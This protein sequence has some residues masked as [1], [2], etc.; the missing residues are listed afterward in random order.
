MVLT[1]EMEKDFKF[2]A[3]YSFVERYKKLPFGNRIF[4][5]NKMP[6]DNR[7]F[8]NNKIM[9]ATNGNVFLW[10]ETTEENPDGFSVWEVQGKN[11]VEL[12]DKDKEELRNLKLEDRVFSKY[13]NF[14][15]EFEFNWDK[16]IPLPIKLCSK[17]QQ[18]DNDKCFFDFAHND[19]I[20]KF[21]KGNENEVVGTYE[22]FISCSSG[23]D[24]KYFFMPFWEIFELLKK[25]KDK[26]KIKYNIIK[27][28]PLITSYVCKM[29]S[30]K[31]NVISL[32]VM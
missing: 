30:G 26:V 4:W 14:G 28:D 5:N 19:F 6:F 25:T 29:I 12:K 21:S 24:L 16:S 27:Q 1:K 18:R 15:F 11:F 20:V 7:I 10:T 3:L 32:H 8:W 31:W 23:K 17:K 2:M 13:N 22:G 9:F